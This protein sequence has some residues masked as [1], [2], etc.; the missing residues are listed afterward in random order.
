MTWQEV[1]LKKLCF[2]TRQQDP[3]VKPDKLFSYIDISSIDRENKV[4]TQALNIVGSEAP[5]RARKEIRAGDIL[6]STVRPNLNAV[7]EVPEEYD[8]QIASTG[9]CVIRPDSSLLLNRYLFYYSLNSTF[10]N[11]LV[12]KVRGAHY[13]AVSDRDVKNVI[14][15]LPPL[16]EQRRIVE[17]LDQ[18]DALRKKRAEADAKIERMLPALFY[19]IFGDPATNPKGWKV[20]SLNEIVSI[21]TQL[22][23]PNQKKYYSLSHI[24]GEDIEKDTGRILNPKQVQDS[25]IR[26]SKFIFSSKHIL[27]SK[28]RPYLNKVAYPQFDGVCSA[29]I[30]PVLPNHT[31]VKP[32]YLISVLRSDNF[33]AYARQHSE[34]LRIP[35]L[36]KDQ[37]AGYKIILPPLSSQELFEKKAKEIITINNQSRDRAKKIDMLFNS[38]LYRAFSGDL[39]AKWREAHMKE[40][41]KEMEEQSKLLHKE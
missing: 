25:A 27:Y 29:D 19:K 15:P 21:G 39:T 33:L 31:K 2:S 22:I 9:F 20:I 13:P 35:K 1:P 11:T 28:I 8:N 12:K 23:N 41:L 38:L 3:R 32:Y 40:L 5:S 10:I 37:L 30:Y 16:S 24:G 34:R 26:S 36:N 17:I 18:T 4:I 7:A 6:V 14:I